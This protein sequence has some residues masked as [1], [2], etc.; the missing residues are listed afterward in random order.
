MMNRTEKIQL[1]Q[2]IR[3]ANGHPDIIPRLGG[4]YIVPK[5][6]NGHFHVIGAKWGFPETMDKSTF[7]SY[8]QRVASFN[9]RRAPFNLPP[10]TLI[11]QN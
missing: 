4:V 1:L 8:Q 3:A 2:S 11:I 10:M 7:A 9:Q 5:D 6:A